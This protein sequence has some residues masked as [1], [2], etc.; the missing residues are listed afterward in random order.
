MDNR[1]GDKKVH[2]DA[3]VAPISVRRPLL[4]D[5]HLAAND[6]P[7]NKDNCQDTWIHSAC[8]EAPTVVAEG[9]EWTFL[10]VDYR[11][12]AHQPISFTNHLGYK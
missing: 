10:V 12:K 3:H 11:P 1:T 5:L 9:T 7:D 2:K 8:S 6:R 4:H